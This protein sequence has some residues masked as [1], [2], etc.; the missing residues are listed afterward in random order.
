M[1]KAQQ[2]TEVREITDA[3]FEAAVKKSGVVLVD[4]FA[5][6]CMPCVM[7][8]PI[9]DELAQTFKNKVTFI[10]VNIDENHDTAE[11]FKIMSIPTLLIFKKGDMVDRIN[12]AQSYDILKEKLEKYI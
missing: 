7:L 6:W 12:G 9:I 3:E 4:F 11:K 1:A 8:V 5:E 10:K 2:E